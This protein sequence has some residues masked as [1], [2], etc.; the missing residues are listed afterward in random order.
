M[1]KK[2]NHTNACRRACRCAGTCS[3]EK[4]ELELKAR[5]NNWVPKTVPAIAGT[6]TSILNEMQ[7]QGRIL[8]RDLGFRWMHWYAL[9]TALRTRKETQGTS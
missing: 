4:T 3:K 5:K 7:S 2:V 6:L 9:R 8:S 1:S